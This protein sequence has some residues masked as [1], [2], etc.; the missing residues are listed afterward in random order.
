MSMSEKTDA[1]HS[2]A[3]LSLI[4]S[5]GLSRFAMAYVAGAWGMAYVAVK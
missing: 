3:F 1:T 5:A 4:P 2:G